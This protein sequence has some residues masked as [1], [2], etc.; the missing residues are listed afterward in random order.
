LVS[1][2]WQWSMEGNMILDE[3][4]ASTLGLAS[5]VLLPQ[6]LLRASLSAPV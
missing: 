2:V 3:S 1:Y 6:P 4:G 5:L